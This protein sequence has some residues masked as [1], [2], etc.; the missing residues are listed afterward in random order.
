M[1]IKRASRSWAAF[2]TPV[3][4]SLHSLRCTCHFSLSKHCI[5]KGVTQD[6]GSDSA[7]PLSVRQRARSE[8]GRYSSRPHRLCSVRLTLIGLSGRMPSE[9]GG[10]ELPRKAFK[11]RIE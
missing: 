2:L 1:S 4:I 8:R 5:S 7:M 6:E 3:S 10:E 11:D 9:P